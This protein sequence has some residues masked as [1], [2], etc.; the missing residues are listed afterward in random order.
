MDILRLEVCYTGAI[1][2]PG[3]TLAMVQIPQTGYFQIVAWNLH[4]GV[5]RL[6][7]KLHSLTS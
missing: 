1:I 3:L 4:D 7:V 5:I 6:S 2:V